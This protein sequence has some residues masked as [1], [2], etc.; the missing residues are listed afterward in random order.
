MGKVK[1]VNIVTNPPS[2]LHN[3]SSPCA[4]RPLWTHLPAQGL[5]LLH[6]GHLH[7]QPAAL[8]GLLHHH[9]G[10]RRGGWEPQRRPGWWCR[11]LRSLCLSP[12]ASASPPQLRSSEKVLPIPLFCIAAT[13]VVWAAALYFFFQ[14][15]SS[16]EVRDVFFSKV[17]LLI[18][19]L[20]TILLPSLS[21][22]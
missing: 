10:K 19:C 11:K 17:S 12:A 9:E 3:N 18:I 4:Q 5:C 21:M 8:P 15:L 22:C 6:V 14:N 13:A 2:W 20:L 1:K 7:R 16:W